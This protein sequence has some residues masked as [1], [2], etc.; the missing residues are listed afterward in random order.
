MGVKVGALVGVAVGLGVAVVVL[1][2][3]AREGKGMLPVWLSMV[4]LNVVF[5]AADVFLYQVLKYCI[6][7][8]IC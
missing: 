4:C 1:V 3:V 2:G 6:S 5:I 8:L 7:A